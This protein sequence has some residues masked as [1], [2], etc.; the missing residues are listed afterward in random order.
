MA[1]LA[2][3]RIGKVRIAIVGD[4]G[5]GKSSLVHLIKGGKLGKELART[6]G[7]NTEV[8]LV[9]YPELP[10]P[11]ARGGGGG[12]AATMRPHFVELWDVA[13]TPYKLNSAGP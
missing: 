7:C 6:I 5:C 10:H 1:S 8:K 2:P 11:S 12:G 3:E 4:T 9:H 13:G